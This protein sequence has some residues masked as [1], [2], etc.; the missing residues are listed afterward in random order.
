M[1]LIP[2]VLWLLGTGSLCLAACMVLTGL[3]PRHADQVSARWR[4]VRRTDRRTPLPLVYESGWGTR[5]THELA[6]N[7]KGHG[8]Q[9]AAGVWKHL[10]EYIEPELDLE[11][12]LGRDLCLSPFG[13]DSP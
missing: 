2:L 10:Q 9:G 6:N 5:L 7:P 11:G 12:S 13:K 3:W 8:G 1:A 4:Q